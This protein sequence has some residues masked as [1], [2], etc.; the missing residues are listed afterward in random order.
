MNPNQEN[1]L[2]QN[3]RSYKE[4]I[5]KNEEVQKKNNKPKNQPS[6]SPDSPGEDNEIIKT[7]K[8]NKKL[9]QSINID[10]P[11]PDPTS[12]YKPKVDLK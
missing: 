9:I 5:S 10:I 11:K 12:E 7:V 2:K 8:S 6:L 1:I 3:I 4:E